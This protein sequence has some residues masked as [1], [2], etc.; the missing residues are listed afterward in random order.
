MNFGPRCYPLHLLILPTEL[1]SLTSLAKFL[2]DHWD[3][4]V[5]ENKFFDLNFLDLSPEIFKEH[6]CDLQPLCN[7][8][9]HQQ[10]LSEGYPLTA[11]TRYCEINNPLHYHLTDL[12]L[13]SVLLS[14]SL[15]SPHLANQFLIITNADNFYS[16]KFLE[17]TIEKMNS[18]SLDLLL[19]NMIHLGQAMDVAPELGKMDLGCAVIRLEFLQRHG[20]TF[21]SSL[22]IPT[23]PQHWHDADYWLIQKMIDQGARVATLSQILFNHN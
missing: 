2:Q 11:L 8:S 15:T 19:T 17:L 22:P 12:A 10:K 21:V 13:Q 16:P 18:E 3:P 5:I 7:P 4:S 1:P 6:C 9:W 23:E 14:S 20:I